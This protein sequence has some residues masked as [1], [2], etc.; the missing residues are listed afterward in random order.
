LF[1]LLTGTT[2]ETFYVGMIVKCRIIMKRDRNYDRGVS[3]Q[4]E[5]TEIMGWI[6]KE[7][8]H[9]DFVE[10]PSDV[11]QPDETVLGRI[12]DI[13]KMRFNVRISCKM[14][15][16]KDQDMNRTDSQANASNDPY[17]D[18]NPAD[19]YLNPEI[20]EKL[21]KEAE[22]KVV[23]V[24]KRAIVH[25]RFQNI[26][27]T[28]AEEYLRSDTVPV[29]YAFFRPSSRDYS[30]LSISW[31][32]ATDL[33]VHIEIEEIDKP[34]N[35]SLGKKLKIGEDVF[36]DLDDVM[37]NFIDPLVTFADSVTS[38][39]RFKAGR[40]EEVNNHLSEAKQ[41]NEN[42]LPYAFALSHDNPGRFQLCYLPFKKVLREF[43]TVTPK[44]L[45]YRKKYFPN[46][47]RLT[48]FFKRHWND[49]QSNMGGY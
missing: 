9:N 24:F 41:Q 5:H 16:L 20:E 11:V 48:D 15:D 30:H 14:N 35:L 23:Q 31:K 10:H 7:L 49:Q 19:F 22:A 13:S 40:K 43:I 29:G 45:R 39:R 42:D 12:M 28:S 26:N 3:C 8:L 47:A 32:F 17:L 37:A 2:N 46:A 36:D 1:D 18:E 44:G 25:P 21:E 4:L 34:N 27:S 33:F 6:P 38:H